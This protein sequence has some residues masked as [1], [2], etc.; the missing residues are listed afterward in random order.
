[1]W[2]ELVAA[3]EQRTAAFYS[4]LFDWRFAADPGRTDLQVYL[5]QS[6]TAGPIC[7]ARR[8]TPADAPA[9]EHAVIDGFADDRWTVRLSPPRPPAAVD[10]GGDQLLRP[11]A[12]GPRIGRWAAPQA[13]CFFELRTPDVA[14]A[15][16]WMTGRLDAELVEG[17][18]GAL[19]LRSA[20]D[21]SITVACVAQEP[22]PARAGWT[23]CVQVPALDAVVS[24]A[25]AAG[26]RTVGPC[27][28]PPGALGG[29]A[30]E[31]VD[32]GGARMIVIEHGPRHGRR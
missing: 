32:P 17:R 23:P 30:V 26:A 22:D 13:L 31:V 27:D 12:P 2:A 21:P 4:S 18:G 14:G 28:P 7:G 3:D 1:M 11:R 10:P 16:D 5:D 6:R 20:V 29:R 9:P 25:E 15:R 8:R 24:A 19:L